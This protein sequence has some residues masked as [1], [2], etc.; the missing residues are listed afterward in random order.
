MISIIIDQGTAKVLWWY[1][2]DCGLGLQM[3]TGKHTA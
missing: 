3:L 2:W 1:A